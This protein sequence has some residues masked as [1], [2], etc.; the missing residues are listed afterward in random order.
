MIHALGLPLVI[1][2]SLAKL[3]T[4]IWLF[5]RT[6]RTAAIAYLAYLI[7]SWAAYDSLVRRTVTNIQ[8]NGAMLWLGQ[9]SGEQV[10]NFLFL[11][12]YISTSVEALLFIWLL[13]RD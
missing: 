7:I 6:R 1:L 8:E 10:S 5:Y 13:V 9:T 11:A 3:V 12:R 4:L 2:L